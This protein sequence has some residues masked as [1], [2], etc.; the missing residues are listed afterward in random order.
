MFFF[1][2]LSRHLF[3]F[4][5]LPI[6]TLLT[7]C[8]ANASDI[9][10]DGMD[11]MWE[12][13]H[14]GGLSQDGESD[15]DADGTINRTEFR[16]G[17]DPKNGSSRFSATLSQSGQLEWPSAAGVTFAIQRAENP[18]GKWTTLSILPGTPATANYTDPTPPPGRAFYRIVCYSPNDGEFLPISSMAWTGDSTTAEAGTAPMP[19]GT[20]TSFQPA[21]VNAAIWWSGREIPV[22]HDKITNPAAPNRTFA[23]GGVQSNALAGQIAKVLASAPKPS[24]CGIKIGT[25]DV[26]AY[27]DR[28]VT[29][30]NVQTAFNQ[31][32]AGGVEPIL[33]SITPWRAEDPPRAALVASLNDAYQTMAAANH[34]LFVDCRGT[35]ESAP[36]TERDGMLFDNLHD[37]GQN[38]FHYGK[39]AA[40]SI[41]Q[42]LSSS[43]PTV[44]EVGTAANPEP[45]W[46]NLPTQ[47]YPPAG[48]VTTRSL[49]ARTDGIPGNWL[50]AVISAKP[51]P[52]IGSGNAGVSYAPIPPL[53][54]N[55]F[56]VVH[57]RDPNYSHGGTPLIRIYETPQGRKILEVRMETVNYTVQNSAATVAAAV[58]ADP[59]ASQYLVASLTGD[60]SS[61]CAY[62]N[63]FTPWDIRTNG[64]ANPA[65]G[66]SIRAVAEVKLPV[67]SQFIWLSLFRQTPLTGALR[68]VS[69]I[70]NINSL[71]LP[72]GTVILTTPWHVVQEGDSGFKTILQFGGELGTYEV[73]RCWVQEKD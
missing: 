48:A 2:S 42:R 61:T 59:V 1:A 30:T 36:G 29:T 72:D 19:D 23:V 10:R 63:S 57:R 26:N 24:H 40:S 16:L 44:W 9:D 38:A 73:G 56:H 60:G 28:N 47:S 62:G 58:N 71:P 4:R 52:T 3:G 13:N 32:R 27:T 25:N 65:V 21:H 15:Q 22:I 54:F 5:V 41:L 7:H 37:Y 34:V 50:R 51:A 18:G 64:F 70:G 17:L 8:A 55:D 6:L 45:S 33:Y 14:F 66:K 68:T 12:T 20:S 35:T 39:A 11:D 53:S 69:P 49:V 43:V 67:G 46:Q 31:L